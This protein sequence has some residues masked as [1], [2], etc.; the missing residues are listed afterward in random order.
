MEGYEKTARLL[1]PHLRLEVR[2][3]YVEVHCDRC[4]WWVPVRRD[5]NTEPAIFALAQR[6]HCLRAGR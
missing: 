5:N 2:A 6:H 1:P 3:R 4:G